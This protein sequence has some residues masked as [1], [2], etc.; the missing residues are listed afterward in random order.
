MKFLQKH[1]LAITFLVIVV[2]LIYQTYLLAAKL[3]AGFDNKVNSILSGPTSIWNWFTG[4]GSF[5]GGGG[6]FGGTGA[7]GSW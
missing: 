1:W 3:I 5:V 6:G 7:S 2:Y 4:D